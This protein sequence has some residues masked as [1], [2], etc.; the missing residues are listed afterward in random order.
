[1]CCI[2]ENLKYKTE[3]KCDDK[4]V[5]NLPVIVDTFSYFRSNVNY[6]SKGTTAISGE[7]SDEDE[8][9]TSDKIEKIKDI[10][11]YSKRFF[12]YMTKIVLTLKY[13]DLLNVM[14]HDMRK[15]IAAFED[16]KENVDKVTNAFTDVEK[17]IDNFDIKKGAVDNACHLTK[18]LYYEKDGVYNL[19]PKIVLGDDK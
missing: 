2:M 17:D 10:N 11:K 14:H 15:V 9:D 18:D 8:I 16:F 7:Y 4:F 19:K 13:G 1:M 12:A 6:V 3:Y 5:E